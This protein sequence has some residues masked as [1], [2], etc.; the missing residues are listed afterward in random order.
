[1]CRAD[2]NPAAAGPLATLMVDIADV[3]AAREGV[4]RSAVRIGPVDFGDE[5]DAPIAKYNTEKETADV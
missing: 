3:L 5:S 2:V 4:D 1:M